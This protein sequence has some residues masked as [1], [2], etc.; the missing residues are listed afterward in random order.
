MTS[1]FLMKLLITSVICLL[2]AYLKSTP[3][4]KATIKRSILGFWSLLAENWYATAGF[5]ALFSMCVYVI[6]GAISHFI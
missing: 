5:I 1:F 3:E 2:I 6:A 4:V